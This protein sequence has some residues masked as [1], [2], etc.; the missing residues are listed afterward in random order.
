[1]SDP[2]EP[3]EVPFTLPAGLTGSD[4][5]RIG[6]YKSWHEPMEGGWTR[7]VFDQYGLDYDSLDHQTI[8]AGDLD[9]YDVI[10]FQDQSPEMIMD[11]YAGNPM[12]PD[13]RGGIGAD[14]AQALREFVRSGGRL[15]AVEEATDFAIELFDLPVANPVERLPNTDF[16]VP[17][18]IIGLDLE[19]HPLT[20]GLDDQTEGW[21]W[22]S[23]R[24][25]EVNDPT[26]TVAA[27]YGEG[28]PVTSGWILGPQY[29][30]GQPALVEA[31]VGQ[32]S[33]VLF[34]FQPNYR[35]QTVATWPL[36][37]NA[38]MPAQRPAMDGEER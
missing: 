16:Y 1:M 5:P 14:G 34:G 12:P 19:P 2:I 35:A 38:L 37:L 27:H 28:N 30:A 32:G 23:S 20:T 9:E 25:F 8:A 15:V 33:V 36:L 13:Y 7:W 11:G 29:L 3:P 31:A 26:V 10:L 17:G 21:Y 4:A 6:V 18:S 22:R 24:A